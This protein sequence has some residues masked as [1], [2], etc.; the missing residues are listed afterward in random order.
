MA[1]LI[2]GRQHYEV[3]GILF[4]KDGTLLDFMALWGSWCQ[5]AYAHFIARFDGPI[6]PLDQLWGLRLDS[7]GQAIDYDRNGP[8]AMGSIGD[9]LSTLAWQS[10]QQGMPWGESLRLARACKEA[11]DAETRRIR[12]ARPLPGVVDFVQK[13]YGSGLTLGVV[14]AD[15]TEDSKHH[16]EWMG[17][18]H[19]FAS[20]IGNDLVERGK[21]FPDMVY[22]ACAELGLAPED[23]A[24]IGDTNGD[25]Q[26]GNAAGVAATIGIAASEGEATLLADAKA[27]IMSYSEVVLEQ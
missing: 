16:L 4:D 8:V 17:I 3:K 24:V 22:Q 14:T 9:L 11:A 10:Y 13:C 27:I 18:S 23:V 15:E 2:V 12:P 19:L 26:M 21:P 1:R 25:M 6:A 5:L 7:S 20:V